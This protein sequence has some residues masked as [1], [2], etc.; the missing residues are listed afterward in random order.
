MKQLSLEMVSRDAREVALR[1]MCCCSMHEVLVH[2]LS[3]SAGVLPLL[4]TLLSTR[5][6]REGMHMG[7]ARDCALSCHVFS[8]GT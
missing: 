5:E 1:H 3:Q 6:G 8:Q 2:A 7:V 4:L